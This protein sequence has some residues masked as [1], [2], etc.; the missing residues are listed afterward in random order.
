ML[1]RDHK[2]D[3]LAHFNRIAS[4]YESHSYGKQTRRVHQE[5]VK[6]VNQLAPASVL[7]IGCGTGS[8]LGL[9]RAGN[10]KLAGDD[11]SPEM[12]RFA[13]QNLGGSVDLKVADSEN[14]PWAAAEFDC[15]TC[16][17][18]FHHYPNPQ[19]VLAEMH[20]VLKPGG[21]L[22]MADPWL[23]EPFRTFA[24]VW[25][26]VSRLGDVMLYS[27]RNLRGMLPAAGF[28]I[29][30]LYRFKLSSFLLARR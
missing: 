25:C 16:C 27:L 10:R 14:L 15:I 8:L 30:R 4:S 26:G 23:P 3:S 7:D 29:V 22:I 20:R 12:I 5:I 13:I 2:Q 19:N 11:L 1:F 28:Q 17:Y 9:I 18:S 21:H 6:L 24:N